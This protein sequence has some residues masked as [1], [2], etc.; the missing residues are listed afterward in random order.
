MILLLTCF[1]RAKMRP[2]NKIRASCRHSEASSLA[3]S[4]KPSFR[5]SPFGTHTHQYA[6]AGQA[7]RHHFGQDPP[8]SRLPFCPVAHRAHGFR[9]VAVPFEFTAKPVADL[10]LA[11]IVRH[12]LE[13]R[14]P[15]DRAIRL[16]DDVP[17]TMRH[18]CTSSLHARA[19]C[20]A[21][22]S[23][24]RPVDGSPGTCNLAPVGTG[25]VRQLQAGCRGVSAS[26]RRRP[27]SSSGW[28]PPKQGYVASLIVL[29]RYARP[30]GSSR[31]HP[32]LYVE[33]CR[34]CRF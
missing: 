28:F 4:S 18:E 15:H 24:N 34:P 8:N 2:Q 6:P 26:T 21:T 31:N 9:Y 29:S 25:Q 19:A 16:P 27:V 5:E 32:N 23:R 13:I 20:P 12:V 7:I 22:T 3:S 1:A 14:R 17:E 30:T 33:I 11:A 10:Y